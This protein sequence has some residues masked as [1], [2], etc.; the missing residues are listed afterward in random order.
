L[1][2]KGLDK[3]LPSDGL[4]NLNGIGRKIQIYYD[5]AF[6]QE[7]QFHA[8]RLHGYGRIIRVYCDESWKYDIGHFE[9]GLLH[10]YG[11]R[12]DHEGNTQDGIWELGEFKENAEDV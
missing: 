7:G 6:I 12:V 10:G 8:T 9:N 2:K 5:V 11:K 3:E 1:Y 4:E